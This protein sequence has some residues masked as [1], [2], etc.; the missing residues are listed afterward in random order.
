[1]CADHTRET[2]E[3]PEALSPL[4]QA[5]EELGYVHFGQI[6]IKSFSI[7]LAQHPI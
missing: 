3:N 2:T 5:L 7:I 1:M 6:L 4:S